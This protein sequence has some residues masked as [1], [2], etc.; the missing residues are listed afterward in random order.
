MVLTDDQRKAFCEWL[1]VQIASNLELCRQLDQMGAGTFGAASLVTTSMLRSKATA[2]EIVL[3]ELTDV[4]IVSIN[5]PP[6][7]ELTGRGTTD[8]N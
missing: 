2:M 7:A 6:N 3:R 8:A 4:E 1:R 5:G